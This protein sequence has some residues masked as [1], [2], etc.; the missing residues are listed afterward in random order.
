MK[1]RARFKS[2]GV[3]FISMVLAVMMILTLSIVM[4][5]SSQGQPGELELICG[6]QEHIHTADC[7]ERVIVCDFEEGD[8]HIH[9]DEC[10]SSMQKN[11]CDIE[12]TDGHIHGD[13]C[14]QTVQRLV[15]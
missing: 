1:A 12:E 3:K 8:G 6:I 9:T 10:Y 14:Y 13:E 7:Y 4:P 5:A 15:Y 11:I 2:S